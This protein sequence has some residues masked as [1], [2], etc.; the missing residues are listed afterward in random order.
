MSSW[1][2]GRLLHAPLDLR[3]R[4]VL[5]NQKHAKR[6]RG[7]R[8]LKKK[9]TDLWI[10][11]TE[12]LRFYPTIRSRSRGACIFLL[13][14]RENKEPLPSLYLKS[15]C[16]KVVGTWVVWAA[17]LFWHREYF[18]VIEVGYPFDGCSPFEPLCMKTKVSCHFESCWLS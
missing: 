10:P 5:Q 2:S 15:R 3:C 12:L 16:A 14:P 11:E 8:V 17:L 6:G 18:G 9:S 7:K 1:H 4:R 13:T